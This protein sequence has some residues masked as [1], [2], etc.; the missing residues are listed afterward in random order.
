[1]T[2][3]SYVFTTIVAVIGVGLLAWA[4]WW[5][6]RAEASRSLRLARRKWFEATKTNTPLENPSD[7]TREQGLSNIRRQTTVIRRTIIPLILVT[8]GLLASTPMLGELPTALVSV[9]VGL[10][11]VTVGVA[12]RPVLENVFSGLVI[13]F[14]R[15]INIGDTVIIDDHY[16]TVE[17]VTLT[18]TTLR[19]WNWERYV[20]PNTRVLNSPARNFSLHD[21]FIWAH[22]E[23]WVS[24]EADL[25]LVEQLAVEG[26]KNSSTYAG[27]EEP[28]FWVMEMG[29]RGIQCWVAAWADTPSEA[30]VLKNDVRTAL[31]TA[32]QER[33]V[34]SHLLRIVSDQ[35]G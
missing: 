3:Y 24:Y 19:I 6:N 29:E 8:T 2:S 34:P 21:L 35:A 16:G 25:K 27:H 23:F 7:E 30:W 4:L 26:A 14:S 9:I 13:S 18:H 28:K 10:L 12:A 31:A 32:M 22:V 15:L 17:D 20:I 1:V 33:G 5:L 11:S